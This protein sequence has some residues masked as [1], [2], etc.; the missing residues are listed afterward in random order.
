[1]LQIGFRSTCD[2]DMFKDRIEVGKMLGDRIRGLGLKK[3]IVLAIP[4]GG[5]PVAKE[6]ALAISAPLDL[7]ITRKIRHPQEPE[8]A[9]GAV[10]QDGEAMFD[11]QVAES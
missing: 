1:M 6:I 11:K 7:V 5:L 9:I 10:T 8:F 3:P 2:R 4:R